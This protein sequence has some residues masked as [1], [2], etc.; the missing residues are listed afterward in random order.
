MARYPNAVSREIASCP[1]SINLRAVIRV[2]TLRDCSTR[3]IDS[4]LLLPEPLAI[5]RSIMQMYAAQTPG[6][7]T[8][9]WRTIQM[10][11]LRMDQEVRILF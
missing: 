4:M 10:E 3:A 9:I 7:L 8:F 11:V 6:N 2:Q 5:C 1:G